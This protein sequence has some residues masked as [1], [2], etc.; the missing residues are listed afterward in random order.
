[1]AHAV[2]AFGRLQENSYGFYGT[3]CSAETLSLI[4]L[5]SSVQRKV[6]ICISGLSAS[7][8]R[9]TTC[10]RCCGARPGT[11]SVASQLN[12]RWLAAL[13]SGEVPYHTV[14]PTEHSAVAESVASCMFAIE[15]VIF[16]RF[17]LKIDVVLASFSCK[18]S[19]PGA[20]R[21]RI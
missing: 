16:E 15:N 19:P 3:I 8:G 11:V 5:T 20:R 21:A 1:M 17:R 14:G 2:R 12:G 13:C 6:E 10:C 4:G 7:G 18:H 9:R